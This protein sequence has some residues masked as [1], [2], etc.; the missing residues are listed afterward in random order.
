MSHYNCHTEC[1][2]LSRKIH[3][4]VWADCN[5]SGALV[6]AYLRDWIE[7]NKKN[8]N[9]RHG[10]KIWVFKTI[11]EIYD[12]LGHVISKR[13]VQTALKSL[14]E[15]GYLKT[16]DYNRVRSNRTKFY[17]LGRDPDKIDEAFKESAA[18]LRFKMF[19]D[20]RNGLHKWI[21]GDDLVHELVSADY[22]DTLAAKT[23]FDEYERPFCFV[24]L[25][26]EE[27]LEVIREY[28]AETQ[29]RGNKPNFNH[30]TT[31]GV[32]QTLA[33][34][35]AATMSSVSPDYYEDD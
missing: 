19:M 1:L 5:A 16:G 26:P 30:F 3:L 35:H 32:Q 4:C 6:Y 22:T 13:S 20:G 18:V 33:K 23:Y 34:R 11:D 17:A 12:A 25:E 7:Y 14:V 15:H 8:K 10:G 28:I 31:E 29:K 21:A 27:K 24:G 2:F 9:S